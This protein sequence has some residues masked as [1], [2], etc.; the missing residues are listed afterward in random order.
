M[1]SNWSMTENIC[2]VGASWWPFSKNCETLIYEDNSYTYF[3]DMH[4]FF[5]V[6]DRIFPVNGSITPFPCISLTWNLRYKT[7]YTF[8]SIFFFFLSS[9]YF[10]RSISPG[11]TLFLKCVECWSFFTA[12]KQILSSLVIAWYLFDPQTSHNRQVD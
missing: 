6:P 8:W 10:S 4:T 5:K 3:N 2:T 7:I 11:Q 1:I 9:D 12:F